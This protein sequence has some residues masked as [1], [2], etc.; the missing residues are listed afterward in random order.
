MRQGLLAV[1]AVMMAA[2]AAA[3]ERPLRVVDT[4]KLLFNRE[5]GGHNRELATGEAMA[6]LKRLELDGRVKREMRD[7]TR[8]Y[9]AA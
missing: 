3:A 1:L 5:I 2:A 6:H 7:G 4:F 9:S 8:W